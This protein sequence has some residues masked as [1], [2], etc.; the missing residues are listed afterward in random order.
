MAELTLRRR[1]AIKEVINQNFTFSDL[2]RRFINVDSSTGN[3]YCPFHENHSTPAAKMYWDE[4]R[5]IWVIWCFTEHK[6]FTTY[7]YVNL[8]L[9]KQYQKYSSPLDFL[10]KNFPPYELQNYLEF[11]EKQN[12]EK[13]Q[14][15]TTDK[16]N[17]IN[18]VSYQN[19]TI[20]DYIET[21][22]TG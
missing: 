14:E 19:E 7:D 6:H 22:Y 15:L 2:S 5:D 13:Y 10:K 12:L 9:C 20:A 18:N 4:T 8:I 1:L 21:I 16:I 17:Y 3:I 11:Y